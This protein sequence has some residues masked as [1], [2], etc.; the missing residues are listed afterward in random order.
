MPEWDIRKMKEQ[1]GSY[2]LIMHNGEATE[3][4]D[5]P[6]F[7]VFKSAS[8]AKKKYDSFYEECK[9]NTPTWEEGDNWFVSKKP[10]VCDAFV[11]RMNYLNG[12]VIISADLDIRNVCGYAVT[13]TATEQAFDNYPLKD[14]VIENADELKRFVLKEMQL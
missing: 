11:I 13:N 5:Q 12:N 1:H 2:L 10:G 14:Y 6:V 4:R 9:C 7:R 3:M 8:E